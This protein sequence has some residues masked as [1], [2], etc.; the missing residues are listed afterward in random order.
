MALLGWNTL[1]LSDA[2]YSIAQIRRVNAA[3][4]KTNQAPSKPVYAGEDR[5][6]DHAR[7]EHVREEIVV[8]Q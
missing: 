6:G 8:G 5:R 7:S 3:R 2:S 1:D 4:V